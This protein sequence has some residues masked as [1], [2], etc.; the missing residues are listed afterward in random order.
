[1]AVPA[2]TPAPTPRVLTLDP[3][4]PPVDQPPAGVV[5]QAALPA[6]GGLGM[7][8]FMLA[9]NNRLLLVAGLVMLVVTLGGGLGVALSTR[10]G[11]RRRFMTLREDYL[12][13]LDDVRADVRAVTAQQRRHDDELHPDL[14]ALLSRI[15][16]DRVRAR[17]RRSGTTT[18]ARVGSGTVPHPVDIVVPDGPADPSTLR[19]MTALANSYRG[20]AGSPLLVDL[21]DGPITIHGPAEQGRAVLRALILQIA[22]GTAPE[23]CSLTIRTDHPDLYRWARWLPHL[24]IPTDWCRVGPLVEPPPTSSVGGGEIHSVLVVD[25]H[26]TA[27]PAPIPAGTGCVIT[28]TEA[29]LEDVTG[30]LVHLGGDM[31]ILTATRCV[32]GRP[33][34]ATPDLAETIARALA[35]RWSVGDAGDDPDLPPPAARTLGVDDVELFDPERSWARAADLVVSVGRDVEGR[36]VRLDIKEAAR[37]G[38]GP[39]GLLVGATGS[40]KS[41]LLRSIVLGLAATHHP[42]DLAFVL[43]DYKGGATF[44]GLESLPHV[45]GV[46]TNL[47]DDLGLVDRV[48]DALVGELNRRQQIL[49][50]AGRLTDIYALRAARDD[51]A[52]SMP[53]LVV[54]VDEFAELLTAAPELHDLFTAI[55]RIGRSIGVHQLLASQRLDDGRLRGLEPY[56]SYR[57]ALRTFTPEE[58]RAVIGSSDAAELPSIPGVGYLRTDTTVRFQAAY[59]S[60]PPPRRRTVGPRRSVTVSPW[61]RP[62]EAPQPTHQETDSPSVLD[63][64]VDRMSM[65]AE[66]T[67]RIW[68]DPLPERLV[69]PAP[70]ECDDLGPLVARIGVVDLPAEQTM[71]PLDIDL[72][73][74]PHLAVLG[75]PDSGRSATLRTLTY[76]LATH[77]SP[78]ELVVHGIDLDGDSL[79]PLV[80]LPQVGTVAGR[81]EDDVI[82]RVVREVLR[83][84]DRR[85][86]RALRTGDAGAR[87]AS[88]P[89][90]V[91][92]VDGYGTLRG[93]DDLHEQVAAIATRGAEHDVHLIVTASRWHDLR[94]ALQTSLHGR[95]ELRLSEPMD[96]VIDRRLAGHLGGAPAGRALVAS[97]RVAQIFVPGDGV[98]ERLAYRRVAD[99]YGTLRAP[100]VPM[101]PLDLR[102]DEVVE[103]IEH[104]GARWWIGLGEDDLTPVGVGTD[105]PHLLVFGDRRSGR[106]SLLRSIIRQSLR[107]PDTVLAVIDPRRT[108]GEEVPAERLASYASHGPAAAELIRSLVAELA[109]RTSRLGQSDALTSHILLV[110]DDAELL[111]GPTPPLAP[112]EPYLTSGSDL[113]FSVVIARHSGG[114]ARAL[115]D[116]VFQRIKESGNPGVLL[117][118]DA[119]EGPLWPGAPLR[120]L[121]P[122]R[123]LLARRGEMP[124]LVHLARP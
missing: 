115:Y 96:T 98:D 90:L 1:M 77:H 63:I 10:S 9:G 30:T 40:G 114:A 75:G 119:E 102:W 117:S 124:L 29:P 58:S 106:T 62:A 34:L 16:A 85:A 88:E 83:T 111:S 50:D 13:S 95:I 54:V 55:G 107:E 35:S 74:S 61:L 71:E 60:G 43:V 82:R 80:D 56:L 22:A 105:E 8:L 91:L 26:D 116:P 64:A 112:L 17:S 32:T 25:L 6:L 21:A 79:R 94:P 4:P 28:L 23:R 92:L 118:G 101:L 20:I 7:V 46:V 24:S 37:G 72:T 19:A 109:A 108:M 70:E 103:R 68:L 84:I 100:D 53:H 69:P 39:H 97:G 123:A 14:P 65:A 81:R 51:G 121:P 110:V 48:Q 93:M 57:F 41:E 67:R 73:R 3:P 5:V 38:T 2:V 52:P 12:L 122:G 104:D 86:D 87:D 31:T 78:A 44:S 66:P 18:L 27:E 15:R 76:A 89:A 33:D 49:H 59:V 99:R 42:D 113:G 36:D 120:P 45:A 11:A 47:A